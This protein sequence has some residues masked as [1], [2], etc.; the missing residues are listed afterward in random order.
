MRTNEFNYDALTPGIRRTVQW[1]HAHGFETIDS[2]DGAT[3][4]AAGMEGA[5]PFP[6]VVVA[7]RLPSPS[8]LD[9]PTLA[10]DFAYAETHRLWGLVKGFPG[11]RV[12]LSY[13]PADGATYIMLSGLD[14]KLLKTKEKP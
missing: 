3:N 2:G 13:D 7:P 1:L 10:M 8:H 14:D 4:V 11:V 12:E 5:C 6:M 9:G